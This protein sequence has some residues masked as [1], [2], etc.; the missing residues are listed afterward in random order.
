MLSA[1]IAKDMRINASAK[2]WNILD[3]GESL[4]QK[5]DSWTLLQRMAACDAVERYWIASKDGDFSPDLLALVGLSK[6]G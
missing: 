5:I 4:L 6:R 1:I 3:Q 2:S